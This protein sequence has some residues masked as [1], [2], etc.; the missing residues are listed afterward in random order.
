MPTVG[1]SGGAFSYGRGTPV[2]AEFKQRPERKQGFSADPFN[3]PRKA[4]RGGISEVNFHEVYQLLEIFPHKNEPMAPGTNLGY[5][6]EGL[7][8]EGEMFGYVGKNPNP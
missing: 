7:S 2:W 1:S 5:P 4:L 6:H 8:V 3:L